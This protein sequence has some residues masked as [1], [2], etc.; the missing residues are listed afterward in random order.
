MPQSVLLLQVSF[1]LFQRSLQSLPSFL[2]LAHASRKIGT[3]LL[4]ICMSY[5]IY[6]YTLVG[7]QLYLDCVLELF[8]CLRFDLT[9]GFMDP[10]ILWSIC[11]L[12]L[13]QCFSFLHCSDQS[14]Y[15]PDFLLTMC[16]M[17][18]IFSFLISVFLLLNPLPHQQ[19][20]KCF[21]YDKI[22]F[23]IWPYSCSNNCSI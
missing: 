18:T 21:S 14:S 4:I 17:S 2:P 1:L 11:F 7:E 6:C 3:D 19:Q 5:H 23:K 12:L 16:E 9:S 22:N 20:C 15:F 13:Q 10:L 8:H